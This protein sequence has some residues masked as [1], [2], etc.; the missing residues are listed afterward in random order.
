MQ[1]TRDNVTE[2]GAR[3]AG[4]FSNASS[5][6]S[7]ALR[8]PRTAILFLPLSCMSDF[9]RESELLAPA[10]LI[11]TFAAA[12]TLTT[13]VYH[14]AARPYAQLTTDR[15]R[16]WRQIATFVGGTMSL[17]GLLHTIYIIDP[18]VVSVGEAAS[19]LEGLAYMMVP[20]TGKLL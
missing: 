20:G 15:E 18:A 2:Y 14:L 10:V 6:S 8:R 5:L 17:T 16:T 1:T 13:A 9:L 4:L 12:S 19:L 3:A 11:P 7:H